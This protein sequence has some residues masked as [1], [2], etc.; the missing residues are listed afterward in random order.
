MAATASRESY[1]ETGLEVLANEGYGALKLSRVCRQL[2]VTSGSFYHFFD[3]WAD[4][5]AALLD[6]WYE[7]RTRTDATE[8]LAEPDW[9]ARI[10]GLLAYGLSLPY[11]AEGA[12]RAWGSVDPA[13]RRVVEATDRQRHQLVRDVVADMLGGEAG[14]RYAHWALFLLI[15]YE[16]TT[17]APGIDVLEWA[18]R[19]IIDTL[20]AE[21]SAS[22]RSG[23]T[24]ST[25]P[26]AST[27]T[28]APRRTKRTPPR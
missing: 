27:T 8:L 7:S 20:R 23:S 19:H 10:D 12:I 6:Y 21:V 16:Q 3:K 1:F 15:G 11:G 17:L 5:T 26:T 9:D 4:Y 14:D 22:K 24:R 18:A 28:K 2:G 13:V 25:A